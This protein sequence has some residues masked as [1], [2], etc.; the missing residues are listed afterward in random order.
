MKAKIPVTCGDCGRPRK[1]LPH[2]VDTMV[3]VYGHYVC[4]DCGIKRNAHITSIDPFATGG[5]CTF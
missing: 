5:L 2:W 3:R 4:F 1:A